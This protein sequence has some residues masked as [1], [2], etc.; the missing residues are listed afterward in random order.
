MTWQGF[1]QIHREAIEDIERQKGISWR[2][3]LAAVLALELLL[4]KKTVRRIAA[5][6][7]GVG[8]SFETSR[9]QLS[10][11]RKQLTLDVRVFVKSVTRTLGGSA[12]GF[13]AAASDALPAPAGG[14][15]KADVEKGAAPVLGLQ[16]TAMDKALDRIERAIEDANK[17]LKR[18]IAKRDE[19]QAKPPGPRAPGEQAAPGAEQPAP[20]AAPAPSDAPGVEPVTIQGVNQADAKRATRRSADMEDIGLDGADNIARHAVFEGF[21]FRETVNRLV[22][23]QGRRSEAINYIDGTL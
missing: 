17:V 9:R 19:E 4:R 12:M 20:E 13:D 11:F 8:T 22:T 14:N 10:T 18:D 21:R 23:R 7:V 2:E 3:A 1:A 15:T 6:P 16:K 5:L